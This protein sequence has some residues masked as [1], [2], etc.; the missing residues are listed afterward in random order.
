MLVNDTGCGNTL[1]TN[2]ASVMELILASMRHWV[3]AT[4]IDGFRYDLATVMGRGTHGFDGKAPLLRAIQQ[5]PLLGPLI[6]I[7]EP[8]DVGPGGYQ[9]ETFRAPGMNGMTAT[10]M[11]SGI[12]GGAMRGPRPILRR[13]LRAH[14]ISLHGQTAGLQAA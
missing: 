13:A 12:S 4:G 9:L 6:H 3:S 8:W 11:M 5:D 2:G 10:A 7:A 14:R 1:D